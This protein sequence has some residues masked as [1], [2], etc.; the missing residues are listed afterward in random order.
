MRHDAQQT[1]NPK[2]GSMVSRAARGCIAVGVVNRRYQWESR[3]WQTRSAQ[4]T[5]SEWESRRL[6][7]S[8]W[9]GKDLELG[10]RYHC[11]LC[12]H[13]GPEFD[14]PHMHGKLSVG[15]C[16]PGRQRAKAVPKVSGTEPVSEGTEGGAGEMP[17]LVMHKLCKHGDLSSDPQNPQKTSDTVAQNHSPS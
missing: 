16:A 7:Y 3:E 10:R 17:Q 11:L 5:S 13:W 8:T 12:K 1:S 6:V 2:T 15:T 14:P 4:E 9:Y